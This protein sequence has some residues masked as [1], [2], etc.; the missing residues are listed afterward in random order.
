MRRVLRLVRA[1][2]IGTVAG[3]IALTEISLRPRA[4]A[5]AADADAAALAVRGAARWESAQVTAADGV[6]LRGWLFTP[7]S[8]NGSAVILLHG[9]GDTRLGMADHAWYL[10]RAGFTILLPDLRAHGSSGGSLTTYGIREAG[11][12]RRWADL[13]LARRP[14]SRL[15]GMGESLGAAVLLQ[16]LPAEPRFRAIVAECPYASFEEVAADRLA[17]LSP[18]GRFGVQPVVG[19]GVLYTNLL[20]KV[21]LRRASPAAAI[22]G[23][24]VPIL[25]IHG[26]ADSRTPPRH[27][28]ALHALNPAATTL[29][30][31][32]HA[33][34]VAALY[35]DSSAYTQMVIRWFR[36]HP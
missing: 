7:R 3:T 29:W 2:L 13:V 28:E 30:E 31:V 14:G 26:M 20:Y 8:P 16:A 12:I 9:I 24:A 36:S 22:R 10:L 19:F 33:E 5:A 32:P 4:G 35:E 6:I 11:D 17:Q 23:S 21:D 34:H 18:A 1:V 15:Y 25:L 27:S